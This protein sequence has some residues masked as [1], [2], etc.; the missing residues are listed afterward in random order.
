MSNHDYTK[1]E[2]TINDYLIL[3][4]KARN[5]L[6]EHLTAIMAAFKDPNHAIDSVMDQNDRDSLMCYL[7]K[8]EKYEDAAWLLHSYEAL[9][10]KSAKQSKGKVL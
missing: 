1:E 7:V 5:N 2:M 4:L 6:S 10:I 8:T 9:F 3:E